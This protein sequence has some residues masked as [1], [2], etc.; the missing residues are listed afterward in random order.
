MKHRLYAYLYL[1]LL[2]LGFVACDP[3]NDKTKDQLFNVKGKNNALPNIE[4]T[5]FDSKT[6]HLHDLLKSDG[7]IKFLSFWATWCGP[8]S[9]EYNN[10]SS[11]YEKW[12]KKYHFQIISV[13]LDKPIMLPY[14]SSYVAKK[15]WDFDFYYDKDSKLSK[16]LHIKSIPY[17]YLLDKNGK[18]VHIVEAYHEGLLVEMEAMLKDLNN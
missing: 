18:V 6:Y 14:L 1:S 16:Q 3:P 12:Q 2:V 17:G 7:H 9:I 15:Q 4:V 13:S 8:C 5:D 11:V 10:L